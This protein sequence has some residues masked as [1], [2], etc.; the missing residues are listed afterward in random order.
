MRSISLLFTSRLESKSV[1]C[2]LMALVVRQSLSFVT[3][4]DY[5]SL[6]VPSSASKKFSVA[7]TDFLCSRAFRFFWRMQCSFAISDS[8]IA[9]ESI[10]LVKRTGNLKFESISSFFEFEFRRTRIIADGSSEQEQEHCNAF[11]HH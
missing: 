7:G 2:F 1:A 10:S 5:I 9:L 11:I 8:T 6:T 4:R 3:K